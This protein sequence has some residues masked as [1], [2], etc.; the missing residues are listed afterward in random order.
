[1]STFERVRKLF[2]TNYDFS[3]ERLRPEVTIESI[4][5]DSLDKVEFLFALEKEFNI[6]IPDREVRLV[7]LQDVITS[8]DRLVAEQHS[9]NEHQEA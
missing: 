5:L 1:M 9:Q 6:K 8:V 2:L 7:T 3:E 4:G